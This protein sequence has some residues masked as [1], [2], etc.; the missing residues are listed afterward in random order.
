MREYINVGVTYDLILA[1]THDTLTFL[2]ASPLLVVS[3]P[4]TLSL[5]T[6]SSPK[7][8]KFPKI[9][10]WVKLKSKQIHSI[11][12]TVNSFPMNGHTLLQQTGKSYTQLPS[13]LA[14]RLKPWMKQSFLTFYS[15]YSTL[16]CDHSL[17]SCLAV[18]YCS[19]V[20]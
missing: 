10:N 4:F 17:E 13:T 1:T 15:M 19:A 8:R 3:L 12:S 6:V 20:C 14:S 11:K 2:Y 7:L 5:T 9:T 16:R 18:L